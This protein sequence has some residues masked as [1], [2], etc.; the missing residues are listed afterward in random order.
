MKQR[1]DNASDDENTKNSP[2]NTMMGIDT[3]RPDRGSRSVDSTE[4]LDTA[5]KRSGV[6]SDFDDSW[7]RRVFTAF[8]VRRVPKL[9][10]DAFRLTDKRLEKERARP[11]LSLLAIGNE[12]QPL[13]EAQ[14]RRVEEMVL[15]NQ[16]LDSEDG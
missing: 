13:E 9:E 1:R 6:V 14:K 11:P 15:S 5:G 7:E 3:Q 8:S 2:G 4:L 10:E 16:T 12:K